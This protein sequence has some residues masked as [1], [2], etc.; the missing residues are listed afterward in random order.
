VP[1][2]GGWAD[3]FASEFAGC[4]ALCAAQRV[5][6]ININKINRQTSAK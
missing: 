3:W 2:A 6:V 5:A 4:G 1:V